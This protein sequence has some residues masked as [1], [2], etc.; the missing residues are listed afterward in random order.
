MIEEM[1][2]YF[3]IADMGVDDV[4]DKPCPCG[5]K[6]NI[7]FKDDAPESEIIKIVSQLTGIAADRIRRISCE[8]YMQKYGEADE[9]FDEDWEED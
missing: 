7:T 2:S 6:I 3:E 4:L 9:D 1:D 8:E 5:L